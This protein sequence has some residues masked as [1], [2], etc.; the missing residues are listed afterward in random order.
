MPGRVRESRQILRALGEYKGM[1]TDA[2]PDGFSYHPDF[3]TPDEAA[4]LV[5]R[6]E[7]L[8]FA[9]DTEN[10]ASVLSAAI[11]PKLEAEADTLAVCLCLY[12]VV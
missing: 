1:S 11:F 8:D 10:E 12:S 7:A 9:H 3:L 2:P 4:R 5:R 6:L